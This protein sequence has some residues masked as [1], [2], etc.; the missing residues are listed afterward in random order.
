MSYPSITIFT[1]TLNPSLDIF[2]QSL[3][4]I[5]MQ[6]YIGNLQHIVYD[7]GSTNG[8][9]EMARHYGCTVK[10]FP[11]SVDEGSR[12]LYTSLKEAT[13]DLSVF[14]ESDNILTSA[15]WLARMVEPFGE[16]GV[17][18]TSSAYNSYDPTMDPLTKYFALIG[19]PDPTLYY[20]H[21]SDKIPM[22]QRHDDQDRCP[23][24]SRTKKR[25]LYSR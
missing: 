7:G 12:R 1:G 20:L 11:G 10:I 2:R 5:K 21:K 23:A 3:E 22:T 15:D 18:C 16:P 17:F 24:Q 6:K 13:G 25:I 9:I 14:L 8:C 4:S 19:S